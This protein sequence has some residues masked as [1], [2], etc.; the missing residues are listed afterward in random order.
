MT[1]KTIKGECWYLNRFWRRVQ[2]LSVKTARKWPSGGGLGR[3]TLP[4]DL[5]AWGHR[6]VVKCGQAQCGAGIRPDT[7]V[8]T[9]NL[10]TLHKRPVALPLHRQSSKAQGPGPLVRF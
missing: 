10:L 1:F 3:A 8:I 5:S 6:E 4:L 9:G 7:R 2:L